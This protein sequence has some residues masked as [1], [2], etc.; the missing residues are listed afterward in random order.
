[1]SDPVGNCERIPDVQRKILKTP[2][3]RETS[4]GREG[5]ALRSVSF[6]NGLCIFPYFGKEEGSSF[7]FLSLD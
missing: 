3:P 6:G 4:E 7:G 5:A 1:M 2:W